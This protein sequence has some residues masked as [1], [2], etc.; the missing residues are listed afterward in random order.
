MMYK[1][2]VVQGVIFLLGF[3]SVLS[4]CALDRLFDTGGSSV[5]PLADGYF[6][7]ELDPDRLKELG[8]ASS[9]GL[10]VYLDQELATK[11]LCKNG[12]I[13]LYEGFGRG[14]YNVKG[15]CR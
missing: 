3:A 12:Y 10:R 15:R 5:T 6:L 7:V 13:V 14:Y 9:S 8:G 2:I 11:E 1:R 4:G